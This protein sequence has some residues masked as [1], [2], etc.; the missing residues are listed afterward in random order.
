MNADPTSPAF[1]PLYQQVKALMTRELQAGVWRPGQAIPSEIEL[2][3]RFKVSQG[4]L[5]YTSPSP[6][7]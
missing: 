5:L 7:D 4:C 3:A 2:A 1:S 6:R